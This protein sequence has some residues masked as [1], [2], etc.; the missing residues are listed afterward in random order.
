MI[1]KN[2]IS[3]SAVALFLVF[4]QSVSAQAWD[5]IKEKDGIKIFTRNEPNSSLKSFKGMADLQTTPEKVHDLLGNGKNF[6][7][8]DKNIEEIRVLGFEKDQYIR[9]YLVYGVPWPLTNRDLCVEAKITTDPATGTR[10][11][12]AQPLLNVIAENPD[13]IRIKKYW[14][15]WT[16]TPADKG[17]VHVTLEGF[18]D[19]GGSVPA[20]LYNMVITETPMRVI[21]S[22][23]DRVE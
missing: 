6:D 4:M 8:W 11:I 2:V 22:V 14:Q 20:W 13:R 19:P 3:V 15:K 5:F 9:Y 21:R 7:W 16:I 12:F 10:T 18:V 17:I 23:R 1:R